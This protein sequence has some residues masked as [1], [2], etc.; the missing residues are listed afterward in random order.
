MNFKFNT[1][2]F[3]SLLGENLNKLVIPRYQRDYSWEES[4][5]SEFLTDLE[6]NSIDGKPYFFGTSLLSGNIEGTKGELEV[7]DGQ[8]R[9]TTA[10]I[11]LSTIGKLFKEYGEISLANNIW[12]YIIKTTDDN[13]KITLLQNNTTDD[14]FKEYVQDLDKTLN[15]VWEVRDQLAD[16]E[17]SRIYSAISTCY[18]HLNNKYDIQSEQI[19]YLKKIRDS[20]LNSLIVCI[21]TN[22]K[23]N[24]NLIF[25]ILNS[26]GKGLEEVDLI[27]NA[28][29]KEI[30]RTQPKDYATS[31]WR[32]I[33]SNLSDRKKIELSTFYD[34]FWASQNVKEKG[35]DLY[36]QFN[37][38]I[39][40]EN[41]NEFLD[42]LVIY[43][44]YY[45]QISSPDI[46]DKPFGNNKQ[47]EYK[48]ERLKALTSFNTKQP[49][50]YLLSIFNGLDNKKISPKD[51]DKVIKFL[52]RFHFIY[53]VVCSEKSNA[54]GKYAV[55]SRKIHE[56]KSKEETNKLISDHI[57]ELT[58]LLPPKDKFIE[59]FGKLTFSKKKN[60]PD[61]YHTRYAIYEIERILSGK[62]NC[63]NN[64]SIE[65][66]IPE[67]IDNDISI[68]IGNLVLLEEDLNKECDIK[69]LDKKI[70]IYKKSNFESVKKFLNNYST[71]GFDK[72]KIKERADY[73]ANIF[74]DDTIKMCV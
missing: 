72:S 47:N 26:K 50:I 15:E 9:I 55:L 20:L 36:E 4:Q 27:K 5:V 18:K 11:L 68:R 64:S 58:R 23:E 17:V 45:K 41:Y 52:S 28:L 51:F 71:D 16:E 54:L 65:H 19:N 73:L 74:Y 46:K 44:E 34:H 57:S 37:K 2:T 63:S 38:K 24:A 62:E 10:T 12:E 59:N 49:R 67:A 42:K 25:E 61:T 53:N 29:F 1:K 32:K 14:F 69:T 39:K 8:Q 43:S 35:K 6:T 56:A 22:D 3:R 30:N 13:E 40:K 31:Q 21:S 60:S 33:K 70:K 7:I 48:I 66:I